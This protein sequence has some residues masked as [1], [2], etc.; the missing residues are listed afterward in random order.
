MTLFAGRAPAPH[1]RISGWWLLA[2]VLAAAVTMLV[3]V[4]FSPAGPILARY[5]DTT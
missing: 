2:M 5:F 1:G 4:A 3:A